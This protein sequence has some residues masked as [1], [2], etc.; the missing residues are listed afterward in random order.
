MIFYFSGTGNSQAIATEVSKSQ[1][2]KMIANVADTNYVVE[3][4]DYNTE[5][6]FTV[7][8]IRNE[9]ESEK[10]NSDCAKTLDLPISTPEDLVAEATSTSS[11]T[12]TWN[13]VQNALSYNIYH[14]EEMI[15]NVSDTNYIVENLECN[16]EY[17][18][19]VTSIRN[20]QE[21]EKSNSDCAKTLGESIEELTS[22]LLLYPNPVND[23]LYI[24]TQTLTL[25]LT[26]EI[27]DIYGRLQDYRTTRLQDNL[28]IDV[29]NFKSGVYF[30]MIKTNDGVVTRRIVKQ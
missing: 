11:I 28:V 22:S 21:S 4:L 3:I 15:A 9:Q 7:T 5:Y 6:C 16:T 19:T 23:R 17:C 8:S 29:S 12:L 13:K 14:D 25:T 24:E 2:E 20:E 18:F 27:Y 1:N 10:S 30:V 26:I